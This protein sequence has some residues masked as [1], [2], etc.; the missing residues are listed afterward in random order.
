VLLQQNLTGP[1]AVSLREQSEAV[2]VTRLC[3]TASSAKTYQ[4]RP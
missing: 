1:L 4:S 3:R 2:E